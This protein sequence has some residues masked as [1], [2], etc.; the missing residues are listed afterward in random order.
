MLGG[1]DR[2]TLL[3]CTADTSNPDATGTRRGAI[4]RCEVDVPGA[5]LP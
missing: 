4:E 2:T 1:P 5:G 3:V